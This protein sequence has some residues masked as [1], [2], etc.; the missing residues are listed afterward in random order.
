MRHLFLAFALI[1]GLST[2]AAAQDDDRGY[3][4]K[5]LEEALGGAGRDVRIEGFRGVLTSEASFDSLTIADDKGVWLTLSD[6]VLDW[7]RTALLRG[8]VEVDALTAKSLKIERLPEGDKD[9]VPSAEASGFSLPELPVSIDIKT[10]KID[11][12]VLGP[13]LLGEAVSLKIEASA[14]FDDERLETDIRAERIDQK[15]GRFLIKGKF[16]QVSEV[17]SVDMNVVEDASGI[18]ARLLSLPGEPEIDLSIKGEGL[19]S[20]FVAQVELASGGEPRLK[21]KVELSAEATAQDSTTPARRIQADLSGDI[22]AL[23]APKYQPFFGD[24]IALRVDATLPAEGGVEVDAFDLT[25]QLAQ[26]SGQVRL[27]SDYWPNFVDVKAH[28]KS[29]DQSL[30]LLPVGGADTRISG[31]DLTVQYDA[32]KGDQLDGM[33]DLRDFTRDGITV[34]QASIKLNGTLQGDVGSLGQVLVDTSL[35]ARGIKLKD[36][37]HA[38]AVG[39]TLT[40][41][42]NVLYIEDKPVR[43]SDLVA[44]GEDYGLRGNVIIDA[45]Q[46]GFETQ[47]D[48]QLEARDLSRFSGLAGSEIT[49]ATRI[50]L[51]GEVAPLAGTFDL[52]IKGTGDNLTVGQEQADVLLAGRSQVDIAAKRST[53]GTEI[54]RLV[55]SNPAITARGDA[56]LQSGDS[57]ANF[58]VKLSDVALLAPEYSGALQL[59][60]SATE[61]ARGWS[62]D[63]NADGPYGAQAT[64]SG[65]VTGPDAAADVK[66]GLPDVSVFVPEISGPFAAEGSGRKSPE[67]WQ[68][69]MD[70][71]GPSGTNAKVSGLVRN[72]G[73]LDVKVS[74]AVP[75]GL[76]APFIKPRILQ[77]QASFDMAVRGAPALSSV[78]G[79]ITTAG[80]SFSEPNLRVALTDIAVTAQ[81][82]DGRMQLDT[83]AA[84]SSGGTIRVSGPMQLS[85]NLDADLKVALNNVGLVDPSL[86]ETSVGGTIAVR[87]P[88]LGGANISG[89]IDIGPTEIQVSTSGFGLVGEIPDIKHIGASRGVTQSLAR[90]GLLNKPTEAANKAS[91]PIYPLDILVRAPSKIFVRGRGLNA[92][93]GGELRLT[94]TT[95]SIISAGRFDLI[96]GRLD[97][98]TR[99]FDLDE[100]SIQMQGSLLPYLRFVT[101][102]T[103]SDFTA[104]VILEGPVDEPKLTFESV[105]DAPDDEILAHLL[106]GKSVSDISALQ[107]VQLANAV[108]SLS[109]RGGPGI[110]EKLRSG[111]GLDDLDLTTNEDGVTEVRVGKYLTDDIYTDI[112]AGAD[113]ESEVSINLDLSTSVRARGSVSND[114][115]SA[116]GL[117]F[118]RDY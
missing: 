44:K 105:P 84:V 37:N 50:D 101:S 1:F 45:L 58:D 8:R 92:E 39:P 27:N 86:Y 98:L 33:F 85:G 16:E 70:A 112:T 62:V 71:T 25:A 47:L 117:F 59:K 90:A 51:T 34:G 4:T 48:V 99:R 115:D 32:A 35:A 19:L 38:D 69:T 9:A 78:Q 29:P 87:G 67:G 110:V 91:G 66:V 80:A 30:I 75:L 21:G 72:D 46:S 24:D 76:S 31:M 82:A 36:A 11:D 2:G 55:V 26:L 14:F 64:V 83:S 108:A 68:V 12:I 65:L 118:E 103:D 49:G 15:L 94:G 89:Q 73:D 79:K 42:A 88:L 116:V 107:A 23:L 106:F 53:T 13:T 93:L 60:G 95:A 104:T 41:S 28:V 22:A 81:L 5:T 10:F 17:L 102:T 3:L 43:I 97:L 40:A 56:N 96:R 74:G 111:I 63:V 57:Q 113:G 7:Q 77:G 20:D 109:G 114:G 54:S 18:A 100:G 61:D 52:T 6:V